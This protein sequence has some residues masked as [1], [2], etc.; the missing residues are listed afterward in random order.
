MVKF[1]VD[2]LEGIVDCKAWIRVVMEKV[3]SESITEY[4]DSVLGWMGAL[5][6]I[7]AMA[8]AKLGALEIDLSRKSA[9]IVGPKMNLVGELKYRT[10]DMICVLDDEY[11]IMARF[12]SEVDSLLI[13]VNR[14]WTVLEIASRI[15]YRMMDLKRQESKT[16][17][18]SPQSMEPHFTY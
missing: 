5:S 15:L 3:Q 14:A 18:V 13:Y 9:C 2:T 1:S 11:C 8:Q 16:P 6:G 10:L 12:K 4:S 7:Q 17:P